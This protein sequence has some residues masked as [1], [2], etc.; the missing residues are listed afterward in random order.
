MEIEDLVETIMSAIE[1]E[2]QIDYG[3]INEYCRS[4]AIRA[5]I[6][7][8]LDSVVDPGEVERLKDENDDLREE[9]QERSER[10][11]ELLE[12]LEEV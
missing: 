2:N 6:Y 11:A 5:R 12:E 3:R 1:E 10:I 8:I 4:R 7:S 9:I